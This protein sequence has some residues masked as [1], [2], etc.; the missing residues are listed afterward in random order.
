MRIVIDMQGAQSNGSRS[1][2]IGRYTL[3]LAQ[4]MVRNRGEHEIIL[5][6][7]GLFPD[8]ID[9]IRA[10]FF[11]LLPQDN[12]RVWHA[13]SPVNYSGSSNQKRRLDA[14]LI[15]KAFLDDLAPD[16]IHISSLFEGFS[17]D[18]I[19]GIY[20]QKGQALVAVTLY[21]LIPYIHSDI[22]LRDS[23]LKSW[24]FDK[25]THLGSADLWLAISDASKE[26]GV[27]HLDLPFAN[28][29]N[30]STDADAIFRRIVLEPAR[31]ELLRNKYGLQNG[32]ILYTGG[33]DHRKNI[34]GLIR[35]FAC[36]PSATRQK[37][38]LA[39]VCSV[40]LIE[41]DRLQR[42]A[43][44]KGLSENELVLTGFVSD[45]DLLALYNLCSLFVF[46]SWYEGFGLPALEAMRC[47]APTIGANTSSLP[48]VLGWGEAF[49]DPGSDQDMTRVMNK[50]LT[51][52]AYRSELI[53]RQA[54]HAT[55]FSWDKSAQK[56]IAAM[57]AAHFQKSKY[58]SPVSTQVPLKRL[59]LA[60]VS[61]LPL[62]RSG[63]ADYSA[64]LLPY[65]AKYYDI[66]VIVAQ[67]EKIKDHWIS[68]NLTVR[69]AK[70]FLENADQFD[71]VLYHFG[72]SSYH[73]HMFD[74][75]IEQ[76]GIV[77]LHDFYLSGI[78]AH[79]EMTGMSPN[80]WVDSLYHS[81]GYQALKERF[82]IKDAADVIWR[83][84][85]NLSVLQ[86]ALGVIV[87]S[88]HSVDLASHW[89]GSD[90][91]AGWS[92]V[93][94]LR[95]S[96][97]LDG[98]AAARQRLGIPEKDL[99]ICSFGMLA[100]T[101]LNHRLL[102]AWLKTPF[103]ND[104][105]AHL[106]FVGQNDEG[107]YGQALLNR[108]LDS[109]THGHIHISGWADSSLFNDYLS[110]ADIGVQLRTLS[111]GETSAAVLDCMNHGLPTIV[112]AHGSMAYLDSN[113]VCL[114]SEEFTDEELAHAI[115]DLVTNS[116]RRKILGEKAKEIIGTLHDPER[117]AQQ[118]FEAI[119]SAYA[120]ARNGLSGLLTNLSK[121]MRSDADLG[122]LSKA[123]AK[124]FPARPQLRQL[125]V[126]VSLLV[127]HDSKT[128]IQRVVRKVLREWLENPPLGV[129]VE[130]VYAQADRGYL[131]ARQFTTHFLGLNTSVLRDE[132]IDFVNGDIFFGLD[133][134]PLIQLSSSDFYQS[135]RRQGVIVKFMIYDLLCLDMPQ[136]FS[137]DDT[138]N[139]SHWLESIL[140]TDG[141]VCISRA[142][143]DNLAKLT[144]HNDTVGQRPFSIDWVH[145]GAD[146]AN[147]NP[148]NIELKEPSDHSNSGMSLC[149][150]M[151]GSLEPRKGHRQ[152]LDAFEIL[153]RGG[154]S[155]NLVIVG[156]EGW[157]NKDLVDRLRR[158]PALNKQ[159]FWLESFECEQL[160]VLY[161][162]STCLIVASYGEGFGLPLIEAAQ[163]KLPII[164]R[165]IPVFREVAGENA[166]YFDAEKPEE[167]A[168]SIKQ[169]LDLYK[170]E[171]HPRSDPIP[172]ITWKQSAS[173]LLKAIGIKSP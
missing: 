27:R 19:T 151:V 98:R 137:A 108:I 114:L 148:D 109:K 4:A 103:S 107:E 156:K 39:I 165:D 141:V 45:D 72:N 15:Y 95:A 6:L 44:S 106:V 38:Q 24:Y 75:I 48:E 168:E 90:G 80:S 83:Y 26:D 9:S 86:K 159:L 28:C 49:F 113:S 36:L 167:L 111:R 58:R 120:N 57:A 144:Q 142:T 101:K 132:A 76:P 110:A 13:P 123:L 47:G 66:E 54:I 138:A 17:D 67:D 157:G 84:P 16:V 31:E 124:S 14:E 5:A 121:S 149:C 2:G 134:D 25:I 145:L 172:W 82:T 65:L 35:S 60:Y 30:I 88:A 63:I 37:N 77:V 8:S 41:R 158:H 140:K 10:A 78:Q 42:L 122:T 173:Q 59:R 112:N 52:E 20:Q 152:V 135:M 162:N 21:D 62:A 143:A 116:N 23:K 130:P 164:C 69:S 166:F 96:C 1:R 3:A 163:H 129:R 34:E 97:N 119:E 133:F 43:D 161:A 150:L 7:S 100:P 155:L 102:E 50:G 87:H 85:A 92:V 12:I 29:H 55:S 126:D 61:P 32:F 91:G 11:D 146:I 64:E 22:Y 160:E 105:N 71:R 125:F 117:C 131:Y 136:Y 99:L 128:G 68:E 79:R 40:N 94:L 56:A 171:Q 33:I 81:H 46:P 74:L 104:S 118:Y 53:Q 127:K 147:E 73:Q 139:F 18:A 154:V 93:P 115:N 51:D 169:W 170:K 89:Y 153:W 70:W